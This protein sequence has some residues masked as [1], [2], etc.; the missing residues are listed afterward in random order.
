MDNMFRNLKEKMNE[1]V[2]REV[3][4]SEESKNKVRRAIMKSERVKKSRLRPRLEFVF[5]LCI[6]CLLLAGVG[7][8]SATQLG[9][10]QEE[11]PATISEEARKLETPKDIK[12]NTIYTPPKQEE[13]FED[14]TKEQVFTKLL[15]TIDSFHTAVGKFE[16]FNRFNDLST[17]T[18]IVEFKVIVKNQIGG[19]GKV[20][21]LSGN[22][23]SFTTEGYF[24]G[25]TQWI[26]DHNSKTYRETFY[27]PAP[28]QKTFTIEDATN[29]ALKDVYD[30]KFRERPPGGWEALSLFPYQMTSIYLRNMDQ[31]NIESQNEEVL[32][33]NTIVLEGNLDGE[34]RDKMMVD[35]FRFWV[36]K[37]SGILVKYE[38]YWKGKLINY[39]H[40]ES[41]EI[42][43]PID[44]KEF[45]P[46]LDG[47]TKEENKTFQYDS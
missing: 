33:H 36:D 7:Y 20:T 35:A 8:Y 47:Y 23:N 2:L 24:N 30:A 1:S 43:V 9:F 6:T 38:G 44:T 18:N 31:W 28:N 27:P 34:A 4:F 17:S 15:N 29:I 42:N 13:S 3:D 25:G 45:V 10:V 26:L 14:M 37:D 40:P 46:N 41:L 39:L 21:D 11:R 16:W 5:S 19:Y 32:G 22:R 12:S